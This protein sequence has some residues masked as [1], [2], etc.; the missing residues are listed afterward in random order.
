VVLECPDSTFGGITA[1]E[2]GRDQLEVDVL[3]VHE[4]FEEGRAF[5]VEAL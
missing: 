3:F 4:V 1:M 2:A 5:V